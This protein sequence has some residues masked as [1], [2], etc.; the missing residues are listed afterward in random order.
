MLALKILKG[1]RTWKFWHRDDST[2][3]INNS[4]IKDM[5]LGQTTLKVLNFVNLCHIICFYSNAYIHKK[6]L[7]LED[8]TGYSYSD[9]LLCGNIIAWCDTEGFSLQDM[10]REGKPEM[11]PQVMI[12]LHKSTGAWSQIMSPTWY[13]PVNTLSKIF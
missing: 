5:Q 11:P 4:F 8:S 10:G 6:H 3:M 12:F 13:A 7:S 1:P 2:R 9:R